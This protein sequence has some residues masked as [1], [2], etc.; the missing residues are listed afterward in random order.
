MKSLYIDVYFFLVYIYLSCRLAV[1]RSVTSS[2]VKEDRI[3]IC[4]DTSATNHKFTYHIYI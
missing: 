3:N 4:I 1:F 2:Y